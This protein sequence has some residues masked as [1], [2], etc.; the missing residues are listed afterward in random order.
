MQTLNFVTPVI[1]IYS[2]F[3]IF[4]LFEKAPRAQINSL[5]ETN[6]VFKIPPLGERKAAVAGEPFE[7]VFF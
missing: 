1:I 3:D 6:I 2:L 5:I 4:C 7:R